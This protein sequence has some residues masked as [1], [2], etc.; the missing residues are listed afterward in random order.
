MDKA[1]VTEKREALKVELKETKAEM[2]RLFEKLLSA[3]DIGSHEYD[4]INRLYNSFKKKEHYLCAIGLHLVIFHG[5]TTDEQKT[6]I[7]ELYQLIDKNSHIFEINPDNCYENLLDS[8]PVE[9]DGDIVITDPCYIMKKDTEDWVKCDI[10]YELD[11]LGFSTFMT[12]DTLYG[13]WSCTVFNTN[14]KKEKMGRFCADAGMVT[15]ALLEDIKKYNPSFEEEYLIK[16]NHCAAVIKDFKGTIKFVV[17]R[18]LFEYK[19]EQHEDFCLE[20]VGEGINTKT[21]NPIN[22]TTKQT[23]L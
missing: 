10:G 7:E 8:E 1:F 13:D 14:D 20:I 22:F 17:K 12:R 18:E 11:K 16:R 5:D 23:G 9:F 4:T 21:N 3:F 19:G 15:V 6:D 2:K